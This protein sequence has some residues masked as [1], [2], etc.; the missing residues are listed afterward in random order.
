MI[1]NDKTLIEVASKLPNTCEDLLNIYGIGK[2]KIKTFGDA[3]C[4]VVNTYCDEQG[5]E[6]TVKKTSILN[7]R[8][9]SV[10]ETT[11]SDIKEP[12]HEITYTL[13]KKD[14]I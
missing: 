7:H 8:A 4:K 12:S 14:L 9:N 2:E 5:I 13:Y 11:R 10:K 6:R 1:F 3:L